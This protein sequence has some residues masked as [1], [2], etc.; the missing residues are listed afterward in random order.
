[1]HNGGGFLLRNRLREI[2]FS[3]IPT[4]VFRK[5]VISASR[6]RGLLREHNGMNHH[7]PDTDDLLAQVE[8]GNQ[9]ARGRL[10]DR[11]RPRIRAMLAVR[12]DP[13]LQARIDPSDLVQETMTEAHKRL[14]AYLRNRPLPFYPW[15]RQIAIDRVIAEH[16]RHIRADKRAVGREV[17]SALDLTNQSTAALARRLASSA[18]APSAR[19]RREDN[20]QRLRAAL[21]RLSQ[22]DREILVLRYLEELPTHHVAAILGIT[23]RAESMR[24]LRALERLRRSLQQDTSGD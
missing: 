14:D 24:H 23:V 17:H 2:T 22:R 19:L 12:M 8:Q 1:V 10:L 18:S 21:E 3:S 15:L 5:T 11:H 7:G 9:S 16:R 13:R 4:T 6:L 20:R